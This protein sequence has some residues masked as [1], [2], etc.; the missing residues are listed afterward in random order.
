M[1]LEPDLFFLCSVQIDLFMKYLIRTGQI[2]IKG[3]KKNRV[4]A[5]FYPGDKGGI[6]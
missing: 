3:T 5:V 2:S 4:E 1:K 6:Q